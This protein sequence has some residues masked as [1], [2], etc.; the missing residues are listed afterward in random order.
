MAPAAL[1]VHVPTALP[2]GAGALLP[3][4]CEVPTA[5]RRMLAGRIS[6]GVRRV[7]Y[8]RTLLWNSA[9]TIDVDL[10]PAGFGFLD[11]WTAAVPLYDYHVLARDLGDDREREATR[12]LIGDLRVP[13]YDPRVLFL[14]QGDEADALLTT[15]QRELDE[16]PD[17]ADDR[18]AFYR[19]VWRTKPLLLP[20]PATWIGGNRA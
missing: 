2:D 10:L 8:S 20:L 12:A 4:G 19:A 3:S 9:A 15:W 5:A 17:G 16:A 13:V 7:A 18:L 11:R 1:R 14:R 6:H